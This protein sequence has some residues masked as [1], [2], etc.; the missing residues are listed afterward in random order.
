MYQI[1]NNK[2]Y[3]KNFFL[4]FFFSSLILVPLFLYGNHDIE[5]YET[6]HFTLKINL[7]NFLNQFSF[8]FDLYGPGTTLPLDSGFFYLF[9]SFFIFD[10]KIFFSFIIISSVSVQLI[11]L[12][13]ICKLL[14][15]YSHEPLIFFFII[16][17]ITL[18]IIFTN[19]YLKGYFAFSCLAIIYYYYLKFIIQNNELSFLKLFVILCYFILNT[20]YSFFFIIVLSLVILTIINKKIFFILK[21]KIFYFCL[22]AF[23]LIISEDFYR[24]YEYFEDTRE[25]ERSILI[26][27]PKYILSGFIFLIKFIIDLFN[28]QTDLV[29]GFTIQDNSFKAFAGITFYFS[30]LYSI[31]LIFYHQSK[32]IYNLNI[33]FLLFFI[34][35]FFDTRA[36]TFDLIN[37]A[38]YYSFITNFLNIIILGHLLN[39][40]SYKKLS[41][42]IL[43]IC[44]IPQILFYYSNFNYKKNNHENYSYLKKNNNYEKSEFYNFFKNFENK[45]YSKLYLSPM[46]WNEFRQKKPGK[47]ML[48]K[49]HRLFTEANIFNQTDLFDY[50]LYPFQGYFKNSSKEALVKAGPFK[51][52]WYINSN[53]S[54]IND[55]LFFNIFNINY[56]IIYKDEIKNI[57]F[58]KFIILKS[59]KS[60]EK[61][62]LFLELK[63]QRKITFSNKKSNFDKCEKRNSVY[64]ILKNYNKFEKNNFIIFER[65]KLN[66]YIIK[67]RDDKAHNF[68]L[69]FL[70]DKS[71]KTNKKN[72]T[73]INDSLI[74]VKLE[75]K[76]QL[77]L[78]YQNN[79]RM[80]LKMISLITFILFFVITL[81]KSIKS[82]N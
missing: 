49:T 80:T 27:E 48:M 42:Y 64:C 5:N 1:S 8:Y 56:L 82:N 75:P 44:I 26:Y 52:Q 70:Y 72:L 78:Y 6:N 67:N 3:L 30:I 24:L 20:H 43:L 14:K 22:I 41:K 58:E 53:Y 62:I 81:K 38:T 11:Y 15:L 71:W 60:Y 69:P 39:S 31:K 7:Q 68:I 28:I 19:D 37:H 65:E 21:K 32:K 13:K 55:E 10:I 51:F 66:K 46:I 9:P 77:E 4:I 35:G 57:D 79:F 74:S 25:T 54:D 16:N 63:D 17:N 36:L 50:N 18:S 47:P 45:N 2:Y 76:E 23:T 59:F 34:L 40:I 73:S 61:E 29:N 33:L 12:K